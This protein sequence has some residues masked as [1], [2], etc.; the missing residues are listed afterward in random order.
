MKEINATYT[1][2]QDLLRQQEQIYF[3][4]K[5]KKSVNVR[6]TVAK[7]RNFKRRNLA[8]TSVLHPDKTI[9]IYFYFFICN[10]NMQINTH[11]SLEDIIHKR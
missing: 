5:C 9:F 7:H 1:N 10:I 4:T 11:I 6:G 3:N 8:T 2:K